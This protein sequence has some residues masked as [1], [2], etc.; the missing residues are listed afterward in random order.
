VVTKE[1]MYKAAMKYHSEGLCP[2]PCR[3]A[4]KLPAVEVLGGTWEQ[5]QTRQSTTEEIAHWWQN[6]HQQVFNI[7]IVHTNGFIEVDIDKNNGLFEALKHLFPY[8]FTGRLEQS[9]SGE[10]YHIPLRLERLP[11]FGTDSKQGR[12]RGN[13]TWKTSLGNCNIRSQFCQTVV[14][15]STH[16]SGNPYRF[17][18]EGDIVTLPSLDNLIDWLNQMAPQPKREIIRTKRATTGGSSLLDIVKSAWPDTLS[19]FECFGM[20]REVRQEHNGEW[21]LLGN[22]GLLLT[23]DKQQFYSFSDEVGGDS[24]EAWGYCRFGSAYDRQRQFRQVLLEMALA[25]GI[26]I[27]SYWRPGDEKYIERPKGEMTWT[28]QFGQMWGRGRLTEEVVF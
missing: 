7:G 23:E 10:G 20:V 2:I 3:E 13:R 19:V 28:R 16:P 5:Y 15:P 27:A 14:P 1:E 18:Q 21:R 11:D 22:G 25:A 17:I 12:P 26:D 4:D 8:L 24:L 9:G 6:G